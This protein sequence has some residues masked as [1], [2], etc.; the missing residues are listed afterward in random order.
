MN[1]TSVAKH[2]NNERFKLSLISKKWSYWP[3]K[4]VTFSIGMLY[5]NKIQ[6]EEDK[7][8]HSDD[9]DDNDKWTT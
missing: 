2:W 7:E 3:V 6:E 9:D 8:E 4:Y 5:L 1:S